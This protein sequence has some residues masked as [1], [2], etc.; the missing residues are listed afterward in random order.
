MAPIHA[1]RTFAALRK[2]FGWAVERGILEASPAEGLKP[3]SPE[4]ARDRVLSDVELAA[5]WRAA[6]EIGY[7]FGSFIQVLI[8]TGQRRSEVLDA[9]WREI[10]LDE[11]MWTIPRQRAKNDRAHAVALSAPAV[12]ILEA[13]P[14]IGKPSR[15]LFT[16]TGDTPFSG[17]SK[18]SERL[19][20][21]AAGH[22]PADQPIEPWRLHDLR[23]TFAS[24]CARLGVGVHVVEKALNHTSGTFGGIVGVYQ[25]HDFAEERRTAMEVWGQH[26][27]ALIDKPVNNVIAIRAVR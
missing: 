14:R 8:L 20:R 11:R 15:F 5:V 21:L 25:H 22:M 10:S 12:E 3:P 7:P 18:A 17:V 26:V 6:G 2:M 19:N 23:R 16:T 24:G 27:Q 4:I 9:E 13:L 1:N